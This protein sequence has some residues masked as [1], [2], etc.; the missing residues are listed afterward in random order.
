LDELTEKFTSPFTK[1]ID[2]VRAIYY[3]IADN[4]EYD[5][6]SLKNKFRKSSEP[7]YVLTDRKAVCEGYSNLFSYMLDFCDIENQ[8]VNGYARVSIETMFLKE[9]NHAW[10]AAKLNDN[11]FLFDVTWGRDT[12]NKK[13]Q[14]FYF[15]TAPDTFILNHYPKDYKWS[16]ID[17]DYSLEDYMNFPIYTNLFWDIGFSENIITKGHYT[18]VNDTFQID[19]KINYPLLAKLYDIE[20][21]EWISFEKGNI[22]KKSDCFQLVVPRQGD[23]ILRIGAFDSH[24]DSFTIYEEVA[25]FTIKNE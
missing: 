20:N 11:W 23:F 22:I 6:M 25:Y 15:Q 21:Q 3:W 7:D 5:H 14:D 9:T 13:V 16:L 2:K 24:D 18:S 4:I 10:N 19:L 17:K 8:I 1:D 12:L